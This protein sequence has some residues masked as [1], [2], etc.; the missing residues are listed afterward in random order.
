[1]LNALSTFSEFG[2][3]FGEMTI[4]WRDFLRTFRKKY[5]NIHSLR[6]LESVGNEIPG[7]LLDYSRTMFIFLGSE[8]EGHRRRTISNLISC[9]IA[10]RYIL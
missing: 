1:M 7:N 2:F 10:V 3:H 4:H 9:D 6:A 8:S 5:H